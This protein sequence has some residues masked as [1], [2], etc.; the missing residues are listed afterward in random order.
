MN[1]KVTM[2]L[3]HLLHV[4]SSLLLV[5]EVSTVG[6][7]PL[8]SVVGALLAACENSLKPS[9]LIRIK[10]EVTVITISLILQLEVT[11]KGEGPSPL[12][13]PVHLKVWP[14]LDL[15]HLS[16]VRESD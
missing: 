11:K 1:F 14:L 13:H 4:L 10:D 12:H 7:Y 9:L 6:Y 2:T 8:N 16:S 3:L 5:V 15:D